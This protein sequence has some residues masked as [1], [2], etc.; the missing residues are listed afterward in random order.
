MAD[1]IVMKLILHIGT[2]KTGTTSIQHFCAVQRGVLR[3][4]GFFYPKNVHSA[5]VFNFLASQISYGKEK[6]AK[7]YM[8]H[9]RYQALK[10][11]CHTVVISAESFYAMTAFFHDVPGFARGPYWENEDNFVAKSRDVFEGFDVHPVIYLRPQDDFASSLYNQF[12]KNTL[13][14][15]DGFG[16]FIE[17]IR[18]ALDY[19]GHIALWEKHYGE[20]RISVRDFTACGGDVLT[21]FARDFLPPSCLRAAEGAL[22]QSN[23]RLTRDVLEYKR[24]FNA[25]KPDRSLAF[26]TKLCFDALSAAFPDRPGYEV[27][28]TAKAR[29]DLLSAFCEGNRV[30]CLRYGIPELPVM[31]TETDTTYPGLSPEKALAIH[32]H[33][34]NLME[35]P[36][37]RG[38]LALR[39]L[40]ILFMDKIPGGAVLLAPVR[41]MNHVLRLRF[42]GW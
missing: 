1:G 31:R 35:N 34:S 8:Q 7:A 6:Q 30:L 39:R 33:F 10:Q 42:Q 28:G 36:V 2:H 25:T 32:L 14:I 38:E 40:A 41:R 3:K 22:M 16:D 11:G 27:F 23:Q 9:V 29:K 37:V 5:Y 15:S 4:A 21:G 20:G 13:G 18:P 26:L 24:I 17:K 19:N 12:V